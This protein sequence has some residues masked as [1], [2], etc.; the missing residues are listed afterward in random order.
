MANLKPLTR[1]AFDARQQAAAAAD[2][3]SA[4]GK[5]SGQARSDAKH[6]APA[7]SPGGGGADATMSD[8]GAR[9]AHP[10]SKAAFYQRA[11]EM[12]DDQIIAQRLAQLPERGLSPGVD[13]FSALSSE[14][15]EANLAHMASA[16]GF[17]VPYAEYVVDLPGLVRYLQE[18]VWI[19][20]TA[21]LTDQQFHSAAACQAHMVRAARRTRAAAVAAAG[22]RGRGAQADTRARFLRRV[23]PTPRAPVLTPAARARRARASAQK[24]KGTCRF[25]LE[26]HEDEFYDFYDLHALAEASPNWHEEV[27]PPGE[28][29]D[30]EEEGEGDDDDE[31]GWEDVDDGEGQGEQARAKGDAR[32][33]ERG[34]GEKGESD[35]EYVRVR[36]VYRPAVAPPPPADGG[37]A[38]GTALVVGGG[39][40]LGHRSLRRYYGQS[41]RAE[42]PEQEQV[43]RLL[44]QYQQMGIIRA[45]PQAVGARSG[46]GAR[47]SKDRRDLTRQQRSYLGVGVKNNKLI[48]KHGQ[49]SQNIIFG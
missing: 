45:A 48:R 6:N 13:I 8:G 41:Y 29:A 12:T 46:P 20:C 23:R 2:A 30:Y 38:E 3:A 15:L 43:Q 31:E 39:R 21:L 28:A 36:V 16:H 18:K 47:G 11:A 22:A 19:G 44:L 42:R 5:R 24:D 25:E 40:E 34:G 7:D 32:M 35:T 49:P 10:Q 9:R 33:K 37:R 14:S 27:V 1:E 17:V 26:G 4:G